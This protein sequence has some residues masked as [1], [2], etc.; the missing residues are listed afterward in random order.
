MRAH[1]AEFIGTFALVFAGCGAIAVGKL[2]D[3]GVALAFGLAIA[4]MVYALGHVSGAHFN[5]AVSIGFAV[6]RRFPWR[7]VA[8]YAVAQIAGA[9]SAAAVLRLTLGP[10]AALGVTA[11]AGSDLQALVW[12]AVLT[13]FLMLVITAVATDTRAVGEAAAL[14]IGGAVAL[15]AL[16]GGPVSGASMNP[17]RSL[18]PALVGGDLAGVW[19]YLLGPIAGAAAASMV[20]GY[21]RSDGAGSDQVR[22]RPL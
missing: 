11:P 22:A 6:G 19:I 16:V 21:L 12:E 9:A 15:G 10:A 7:R 8:S 1:V 2:S 4:V 13:F 20:Y 14:A 18:G 5:P 17:A 3:T